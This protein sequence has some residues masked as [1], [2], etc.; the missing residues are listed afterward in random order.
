MNAIGWLLEHYRRG[1]LLGIHDWIRYDLTGG[2]EC[3]KKIDNVAEFWDVNE[4]GYVSV[5]LPGYRLFIDPDDPGISTE[6][7]SRGIREPGSYYHYRRVLRQLPDDPLI[8]E[9]GANIGYYALAAAVERPDAHIICVE[10]D[11]QNVEHLRYNI[12]KNNLSDQ[13]TIEQVALSDSNT[14]KEV[15]VTP[16]SNQ[17]SL[18][19]DPV[20]NT[21]TVDCV[22]GDELL[23]S[24]GYTVG[25][26]NCLRMDT[27]GHELAILRGLRG[28][29]LDVAH[30]EVHPHY[31]SNDDFSN[32]CKIFNTWDTNIAGIYKEEKKYPVD[33]LGRPILHK[34]SQIVFADDK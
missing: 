19:K 23:E 27:E 29:Q 24:Y 18:E 25:D 13:L 3:I 32:L 6:L 5:Q 9:A 28:L 4:D 31:L 14:K 1:G 34:A 33:T 8:L 12:K 22:T 20:G 7:L 17:H 26:I 30:I 21:M 2:Y 15:V 10:L 11:E 16:E